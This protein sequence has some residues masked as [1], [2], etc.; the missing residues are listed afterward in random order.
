MMIV[1]VFASAGIETAGRFG[2]SILRIGDLITG[3]K[4]YV[5][6]AD[7]SFPTIV[8]GYIARIK[9]TAP[10]YEKLITNILEFIQILTQ[11]RL[12]NVLQ[13]QAAKYRIEL[14]Q[15]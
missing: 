3:I 11:L 9:R 13:S 14:L 12:G 6:N 5:P 8:T 10:E 1:A 15:I 7:E 2:E 4:D